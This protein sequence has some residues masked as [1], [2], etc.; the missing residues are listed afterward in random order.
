M[1]ARSIVLENISGTLYRFDALA[2]L[3]RHS[4]MTNSAL[5][6]ADVDKGNE[7]HPCANGLV[8]LGTAPRIVVDN[9]ERAAPTHMAG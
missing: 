9:V 3:L 6:P 8:I 1:R 2:N 4:P 7:V 5:V